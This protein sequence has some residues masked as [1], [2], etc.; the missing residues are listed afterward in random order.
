MLSLKFI[1]IF[2]GIIFSE[3]N[4]ADLMKQNVSLNIVYKVVD[5]DLPTSK[6]LLKVT[7]KVIVDKLHLNFWPYFA[8]S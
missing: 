3:G 1:T 6:R 5:K 2:C 4:M 7:I 8:N